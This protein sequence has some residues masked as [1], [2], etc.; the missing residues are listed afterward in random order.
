[1][2]LPRRLNVTV[3]GYN[4]RTQQMKESA[5]K[6]MEDSTIYHIALLWSYFLFYQLKIRFLLLIHCLFNEELFVISAYLCYSNKSITLF[7]FI[8]W[9]VVCEKEAEK[10]NRQLT[11][12]SGLFVSNSKEN[13]R[14]EFTDLDPGWQ[15][16]GDKVKVKWHFWLYGW[17][18]SCSII[19]TEFSE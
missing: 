16:K 19:S 18:L 11:T 10:G 5:S 13:I 6:L 12:L 14:I 1:M 8:W 9:Q 4:P 17:V 15:I 3:V 7:S 2:Q